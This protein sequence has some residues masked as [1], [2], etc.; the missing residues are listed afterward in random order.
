MGSIRKREG[1]PSPWEA[2]Y[3]EPDGRQRTKA[4]RR[5]ADASAFLST[6]EAD[7]LRGSYLDPSAGKVT[8][9]A[10]AGKW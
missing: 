4:F 6:V 3:R 9:R 5:K 8:V 10:F 7:K 2:V 1:R